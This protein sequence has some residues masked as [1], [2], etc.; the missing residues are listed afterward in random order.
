MKLP[1]TFVTLS[2]QYLEFAKDLLYSELP[3]HTAALHE[4]Y[5]DPAICYTHFLNKN[6]GDKSKIKE[7][8][9]WAEKSRLK[10]D[11]LH[12]FVALDKNGKPLGVSGF[13]S[14]LP[15]Y[16]AKQ[17][18]QNAM[19]GELEKPNHF[20]MGWTAA[21]KK[22]LGIGT[23]LM[24]HAVQ[25][26]LKNAIDNRIA[27][28]QWTVLADSGAASYYR[29]KGLSFK[30]PHQTE[31]IFS[32]NLHYVAGLLRPDNELTRYDHTWKFWKAELHWEDASQ[33]A[34]A[35]WDSLYIEGT[36]ISAELNNLCSALKKS[37]HTIQNCFDSMME[38][39]TSYFPAILSYLD[40]LKKKQIGDELRKNLP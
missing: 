5:E 3:K 29:R 10:L 28:P 27:D 18:N 21:K 30:M 8:E 35:W 7:A 19:V 1:L 32:D 12:Y 36:D 38:S 9:D 6:S 39:G 22:G 31:S 26:A 4:V 13:Y 24:R 2:D 40:Y 17:G 11:V 25:L 15:E 33:E 20:W 14:V 34:K 37:G 23:M 16:L